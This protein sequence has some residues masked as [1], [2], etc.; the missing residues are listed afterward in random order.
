MLTSAMTNE[1]KKKGGSIMLIM[2]SFFLLFILL[3]SASFVILE[4]GNKNE[5]YTSYEDS[6]KDSNKDSNNDTTRSMSSRFLRHVKSRNLFKRPGC[7][8]LGTD[9]AD[10]R[11]SITAGL[12]AAKNR[13]TG[14]RS[15][16]IGTTILATKK[17][18]DI[19]AF[20]SNAATD[21]INQDGTSRMNG[22]IITFDTANTASN[23]FRPAA[24]I[25]PRRGSLGGGA[26]SASFPQGTS[27]GEKALIDARTPPFTITTEK[28]TGPATQLDT[29]VKSATTVPA[30]TTSTSTRMENKNGGAGGAAPLFSDRDRSSASL[31]ALANG[32]GGRGFIAG[33]ENTGISPDR[34]S[35]TIIALG[36]GGTAADVA[37]DQSLSGVNLGDDI[38]KR[39]VS[40]NGALLIS[41]ANSDVTIGSLDGFNEGPGAGAML[42]SGR[43]KPGTNDAIFKSTGFRR[44]DF[45]NGS[46]GA[47]ISNT[48]AGQTETNG[49]IVFGGGSSSSV[50]R[51]GA[52]ISSNVQN[53]NSGSGNSGGFTLGGASIPGTSLFT[54]PGALLNSATQINNS[55]AGSSGSVFP[56][57][58]NTVLGTGGSF[59]RPA[60]LVPNR[61]TEAGE[62]SASTCPPGTVEGIYCE[63]SFAPV[64]C[65]PNNCKYSN[66]CTA[67]VAG[68]TEGCQPLST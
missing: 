28:K 55:G 31:E 67:G 12:F 32:A 60:A 26:L 41:S 46:S 30:T 15:T 38:P 7:G 5:E 49:G 53:N 47:T 9:C 8:G 21:T 11:D 59:T 40:G 50:T 18:D 4:N 13:K 54:R 17:P 44:I 58:G 48:N 14:I 10:R 57:E 23:E 43:Q 16:P 24:R 27:T 3:G 68:F 45:A 62:D 61:S 22:G 34:E 35:L 29:S 39:G 63:M 20:S 42:P 2:T 1:E 25:P 33:S 65:G 19:F 64:I 66:S 56:I 52:M 6:N 37:P 51:P 36:T